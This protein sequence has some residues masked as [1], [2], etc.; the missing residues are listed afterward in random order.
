MQHPWNN[1]ATNY[2]ERGS[3]FPPQTSMYPTSPSQPQPSFNRSPAPFK[4]QHESDQQQPSM[5]T[6]SH[7]VPQHLQNGGYHMQQQPQYPQQA[8]VQPQQYD[9]PPAPDA[10]QSY[11][12]VDQSGYPIADTAYPSHMLSPPAQ[13]QHKNTRE[14]PDMDEDFPSFKDIKGMFVK[15]QRA[16]EREE[17][18]SHTLPGRGRQ[19]SG[20]PSS[21]NKP[22][23]PE[24]LK[25]SLQI[26]LPTLYPHA[27]Q[28]PAYRPVQAPQQQQSYQTAPPR[29]FNHVPP[30]QPKN[31][32]KLSLKMPASPVSPPKPRRSFSQVSQSPISPQPPI[33]QKPPIFRQ[34]SSGSGSAVLNMTTPPA[35]QSGVYEIPVRHV[36]PP[37]P[38][39][40]SQDWHHVKPSRDQINYRPP[41]SIQVPSYNQQV[42]DDGSSPRVVITSNSPR[43]PQ[44]AYYVG[45]GDAGTGPNWPPP[46]RASI[47]VASPGRILMMS[48]AN[49]KPRRRASYAEI[50]LSNNS[51]GSYNSLPRNFSVGRSNNAYNNQPG[52]SNPAF[53]QRSVI[54][55]MSSPTLLDDGIELFPRQR[56]YGPPNVRSPQYY[57]T[58]QQQAAQPERGFARINMRAASV[59]RLLYQ[60][61]GHHAASDGYYED[62]ELF[63][64]LSTLLNVHRSN[65]TVVH[66]L[67]LSL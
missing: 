34:M 2:T 13:R 18:K 5:S 28:Q 4:P 9:Y 27:Q 66:G 47:A 24:Y 36:S 10:A 58:P 20:G 25:S 7:Q 35:N 22:K 61:A 32:G 50:T 31:R 54:Q 39:R 57:H 64:L 3:N 59:D 49:N 45:E 23:Q 41:M 52:N 21:Q 19:L 8:Y 51:S 67:L 29:Q 46:R 6:S 17:R 38:Q 63:A 11:P 30:P 33:T 60:P 1:F 26:R 55:V 48:G 56:R 65:Q 62:S 44:K 37:K 16:A 14:D 42:H 12:Q 40:S 53:P 43:S 15:K